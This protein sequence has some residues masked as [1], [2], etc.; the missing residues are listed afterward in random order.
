M[1]SE[2]IEELRALNNSSYQTGNGGGGPW[3]RFVLPVDD[4]NELL[5]SAAKLKRL[6][7]I[8][9]PEIESD[10]LDA[11]HDTEITLHH[12]EAREVVELLK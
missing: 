3:Q 9:L 1:T 11:G 2:R 7:E 4:V 5:D 12:V 10:W 6:A 8:L